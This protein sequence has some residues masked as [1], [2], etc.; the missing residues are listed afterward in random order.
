MQQ[1]QITNSNQED[2][3]ETDED[4]I[5]VGSSKQSKMI[6]IIFIIVF[7][8]TVIYFLFFKESGDTTNKENTNEI[9][10]QKGGQPTRGA[11]VDY[12]T[13]DLLDVTP[14]DDTFLTPKT[15]DTVPALPELP[16]LPEEIRQQ[17][18][19]GEKKEEK[20]T[21]EEVDKM[22]ND[23]LKEAMEQQMEAIS[24]LNVQQPPKEG[25]SS[26]SDIIINLPQNKAINAKDPT[27]INLPGDN[28]AGFDTTNMTDEEILA[29]QQKKEAEALEKIKKDKILQER[30][31]APMFKISGGTGPTENSFDN[32]DSIILS[33][34]DNKLDIQDKTPDVIPTQ[35]TDLTRVILQGK[36]ISAVLETA[37]DT[38]VASTVRAV[39]TR[40][41]YA[42]EGKNILIPKGSRVIGSY[43]TNI[44][45]GQTRVTINWNRIIRVDGMSLNIASIGA[46]RLGRAGVQGDLDNR[47]AQR[48]ANSFLSSVLSVGTSLAAEKISGSTGI[49]NTI[50]SL[51]GETT[52]TSGKS[53]DYALIQA[54]KDFMGDAQDIVDQI[55]E[56]KAVIRIP[57]GE[58]VVIMVTQDL[59]LPVYKRSNR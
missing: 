50:S 32:S 14:S 41:V 56:Q 31:V 22:I 52:T 35:I 44:S 25:K 46:D 3:A 23:K 26:V 53:S 8:S 19:S 24:K 49:T 1:N 40:D 37:I 30:K 28:A 38:D 47:Y 45:S 43:E 7:V 13:S 4:T 15:Q 59:T 10:I 27:A 12:N 54:T 48:L 18:A 16:S 11:N 9:V 42:E 34:T 51:T 39:I 5:G 33:Y 58:K 20:F 55:A 21:K 6:L 36:V 17:I 29:A 57:Q 2:I